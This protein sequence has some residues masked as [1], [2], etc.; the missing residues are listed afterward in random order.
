M[1]AKHASVTLSVHCLIDCILF[2]TYEEVNRFFDLPSGTGSCNDLKPV[3]A[4]DKDVHAE[5]YSCVLYVRKWTYNG[6][7]EPPDLSFLGLECVEHLCDDYKLDL[8]IYARMD[9]CDSQN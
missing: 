6:N 2:A 8:F 3:P 4:L 1:D 7:T 9:G 5:Q